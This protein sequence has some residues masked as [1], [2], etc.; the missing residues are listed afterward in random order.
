MRSFAERLPKG[1][2]FFFPSVMQ[3]MMCGA[4]RQDVVLVDLVE[5]PNGTYWGW[6]DAEK[7]GRFSMIWPSFVQLQVCF[8]YGIDIEE[9]KGKGRRVQLRVDLID[10]S[11]TEA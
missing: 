11:P 10:D 5:D 6:E 3:V 9:K 8:P 7:P 2:T 1:Y 4:K